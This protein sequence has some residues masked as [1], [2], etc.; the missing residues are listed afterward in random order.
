MIRFN[1]AASGQADS[2]IVVSVGSLVEKPTASQLQEI[3]K[4]Q[5]Q[6]DALVP[7]V[8]QLAGVDETDFQAAPNNV[9]L[10][11]FGDRVINLENNKQDKFTDLSQAK[12]LNSDV[13]D[14]NTTVMTFNNLEIGKVYRIKIQAAISSPDGNNVNFSAIHDGNVLCRVQHEGENTSD[15]NLIAGSQSP[16]FVATTTSISLTTS[17]MIAGGNADILSGNGTFAETWAELEELPNTQLTTKW[18]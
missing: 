3:E 8:A 4:V 5:G 7:T 9:D 1:D 16:A 15:D 10:K 6:I 17:G 2:I 18:T 11:Q 13:I 14:S 12:T